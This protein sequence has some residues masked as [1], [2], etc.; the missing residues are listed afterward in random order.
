MQMFNFTTVS[1]D[2]LD[3]FASK[4]P[5]LNRVSFQHAKEALKQIDEIILL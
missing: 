5:E 3:K 1:N 2:K 4:I